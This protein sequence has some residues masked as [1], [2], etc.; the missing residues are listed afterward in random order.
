[1]A[2]AKEG[3]VGFDLVASEE[4]TIVG[5]LAG[6]DFDTPYYESIS[7]IEYE[8]DLKIE[9]PKNC[10]AFIYPR[11]SIS[12]YNLQLCNSVG[13][14]DNGYRGKIKLRF[15]YLWQ[16]NLFEVLEYK[17]GDYLYKSMVSEVDYNKIYRKGDKIGQ[18][19]FAESVIPSLT[20]GEVS[21]TSRGDGGFGSTGK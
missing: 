21:D 10:F 17:K 3:D 13:V 4:P 8:V 19:V 18:I 7:Y 20:E 15:N 12:K 14:I 11:S 9:P 6:E 2:P 5:S 16:P 1:M